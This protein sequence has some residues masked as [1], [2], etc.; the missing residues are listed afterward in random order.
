[1]RPV[2]KSMSRFL[3]MMSV[4][5][6]LTLAPRPANAQLFSSCSEFWDNAW[7]ACRSEDSWLCGGDCFEYVNCP[8]GC[9]PSEWC[10][11]VGFGTECCETEAFGFYWCCW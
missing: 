5:L 3:F 11:D 6:W 10:C 1:M 7:W 2:V 4:A 9:D 8:L